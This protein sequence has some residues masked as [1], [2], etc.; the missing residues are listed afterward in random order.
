LQPGQADSQADDLPLDSP[1]VMRQLNQGEQQKI[2]AM[3]EL[4]KR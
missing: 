2:A 1:E 4:Q 3:S